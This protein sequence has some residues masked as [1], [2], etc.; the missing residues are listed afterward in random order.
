MTVR[1]LFSSQPTSQV[2]LFAACNKTDGIDGSIPQNDVGR[3]SGRILLLLLLF[4]VA[5]IVVVY[6]I[7]ERLVKVWK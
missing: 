6:S 7:R 5:V 4:V 1:C 3:V 2:R